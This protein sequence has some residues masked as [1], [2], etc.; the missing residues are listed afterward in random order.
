MDYP[1]IAFVIYVNGE[2]LCSIGLPPE[3]TRGVHLAWFGGS[4]DSEIFLG[5]G[6]MDDR[7]H[8]DWD[9]PQLKVG[10][11][12]TVKI[13]D[14]DENDPPSTRRTVEEVDAW[15]RSLR[16]ARKSEDGGEDDLHPLPAPWE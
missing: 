12:V 7:E 14:C 8:V 15:A 3:N 1:M 5:A 16:P 9:T 10:D 2:R 6:G 11:E 4:A 13:T